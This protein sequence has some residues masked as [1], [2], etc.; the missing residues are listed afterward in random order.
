MRRKNRKTKMKVP[1]KLV[2]QRVWRM[3]TSRKMTSQKMKA[4]TASRIKMPERAGKESFH[5]IEK[6]LVV[7]ERGDRQTGKKKGKKITE[8]TEIEAEPIIAN[9]RK[10]DMIKGAEAKEELVMRKISGEEAEAKEAGA[11]EAEAREAEAETEVEDGVN[12][13]GEAEAKIEATTDAMIEERTL[14][15]ALAEG[16]V[17]LGTTERETKEMTKEVGAGEGEKTIEIVAEG[18]ETLAL[19]PAIG[20]DVMAIQ[21]DLVHEIGVGMMQTGTEGRKVKGKVKIRDVANMQ[22]MKKDVLV[23]NRKGKTEKE[24]HHQQMFQHQQMLQHQ[25]TLHLQCQHH[26]LHCHHRL[27]WHSQQASQACRRPLAFHQTCRRQ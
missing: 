7:R 15:E 9:E 18:A 27:A 19:A 16:E 25:Q 1:M 2:P 14:A 20:E 6:M 22:E 26:S 11:R 12:K 13:E 24:H 21:D 17:D 23:L 8:T 3:T 5:A 10:I 4:M